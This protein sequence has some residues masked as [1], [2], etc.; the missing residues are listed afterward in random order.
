[1][2]AETP[3]ETFVMCLV[4]H[5]DETIGLLRKD[6]AHM[7]NEGALTQDPA[8]AWSSLVCG[9]PEVHLAMNFS[10]L[11]GAPRYGA[12]F[13]VRPLSSFKAQAPGV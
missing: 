8:K 13:Q 5:A 11:Y 12:S 1:M 7:P 6:W 10:N 3:S 4:N 9:R 2:P